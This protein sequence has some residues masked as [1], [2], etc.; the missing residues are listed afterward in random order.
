[1][2]R[3]KYQDSQYVTHQLQST[4]ND[5]LLHMQVFIVDSYFPYF[6]A[7]I[8]P[9][10]SAWEG[11]RDSQY[12]THQLQSILNDC[13]LHRQV[14]IIDTCFPYLVTFPIL[15]PAQDLT[16]SVGGVARFLYVLR[17]LICYP[18]ISHEALSYI[19]IQCMY[20]TYIQ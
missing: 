3:F 9:S 7:S 8:Y 5:C 10:T 1:M 6:R 14:F 18:S 4:L 16:K 11:W 19:Q 17:R 13:L 2:A 15:G 12:V 20:I